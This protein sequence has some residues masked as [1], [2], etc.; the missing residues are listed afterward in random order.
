MTKEILEAQDNI[1]RQAWKEGALNDAWF[2][3]WIEEVYA[4][5][6]KNLQQPDVI[7]SVCVCKGTGYYIDIY[8]KQQICNRH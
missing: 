7:K 2:N 6:A 5:Q 1:L 3:K 4:Q 8:G